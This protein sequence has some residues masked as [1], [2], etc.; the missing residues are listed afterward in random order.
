VTGGAGTAWRT[1][2]VFSAM[3]AW[4]VKRGVIDENPGTGIEL[5]KLPKRER[6]LS[7]AE[8]TKLGEAMQEAEREG[9]NPIALNII[10]VLL[11][12]GARKTEIASAKGAYLDTE[13]SALR[14]PDSKTD[15]KVIALGAA[16]LAILADLAPEDPDAWIF[17]PAVA[18][19]S[20]RA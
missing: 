13:H 18:T 1:A 7:A 12:S 5:N 10:R 2:V 15:E 8:L 3:L 14:L 4:S 20:S 19:A 6:F 9:V 11:L 16:P 17:P